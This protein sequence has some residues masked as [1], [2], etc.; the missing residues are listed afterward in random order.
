MQDQSPLLELKEA[1]EQ[2]CI[3]QVLSGNRYTHSYVA[4]AL[5]L[6]PSKTIVTFF[7]RFSNVTLELPDSFMKNNSMLKI[8]ATRVSFVLVT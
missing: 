5:R 3:L 7:S 1:S 4:V 8:F 2:P 6:S